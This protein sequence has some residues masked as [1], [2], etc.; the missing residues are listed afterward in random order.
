LRWAIKSRLTEAI[1]GRFTY[2]QGDRPNIL[3]FAGR[4]GGST[5]L[6]ETLALNPG[7]WW[8][9]EPFAYL[10]GHI[11]H[12]PLQRACLT[13]RPFSRFISLSPREKRSALHYVQCLMQAHQ[14]V[15]GWLARPRFPLRADRSMLKIVNASPLVDWLAANCHVQ[16]VHLLRHPAAQAM[17]ILRN[18]WARTAGVYLNDER[19]C[20]AYLSTTQ[21]ALAWDVETNGTPFERAVLDWV[22]ENLP[23]LHHAGPVIDVTYEALILEPEAM[24]QHLA[25]ALD[26]PRPRAMARRIQGKPS[27]S[28]GLSSAPHRTMI[29]TGNVQG[30]LH[31]WQHAVDAAQ[32]QRAQAILDCFEIERYTMGAALPKTPRSRI[33]AVA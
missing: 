16:I 19:F 22:F 5:L 25:N 18:D 17:S 4:R 7:L 33:E 2:Q 14:R 10:P 12:T 21:Q 23:L 28:S 11:S 9:I 13:P 32:C 15:N 24:C 20:A 8:V 6:A 30:L 1:N 3:L 27:G 26:L 29:Q 31:A